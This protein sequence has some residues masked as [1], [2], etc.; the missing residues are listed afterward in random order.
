MIRNTSLLLGAF[1]VLTLACVAWAYTTTL[2]GEL[3]ALRAAGEV[4]LNEAA[5]RLRLQ[6][7]GFRAQ[8]N[9]IADTPRVERAVAVG[10]AQG[11][12]DFLIGLSLTY[13]ASRIDVIGAG[14]Q[15][16]SSSAGDVTVP[17]PSNGLMQAALNERLGFEHA[18]EE[19]RRVIRLSRGVRTAESVNI[20]AVVLTIDVAELEFQW[21]VTPEPL[22]FFDDAKLSFSSNRPALL[23]LSLADDPEEPEFELRQNGRVAGFDLWDFTAPG[24]DQA[25]EV[26]VLTQPVPHLLLTGQIILDTAPARAAARLQGFL[27]LALALVLGLVAA[28]AVQQR[29]RFALETRHS[30]TLEA[31]VEE[32]TAELKAAQGE[33]VE[34]SKLAALGRLS[35]GVSHELNQPLAA[36][37]NFSENARKFIDRDKPQ[38]V[39]ENLGLISGQVQRITRIIGNLRAF[40]RQEAAPR[41]KIDFTEVVEAA[42]D[43]V[44]DDLEAAGITSDV[45]LPN[46]P[47][48]I[49]AGRVRLEQVVLNLLTNA[50]DAMI[51]APEKRLT[52][53]LE[54]AGDD[55][56]LVVQDTGA[57]ISDPDRVFEP[58]YTTKDLG[59]SKGLGMGLALSF[60]IVTRFG[61]TLTC[62]NL[63]PGAAFK[64]A[65]PLVEET[66][67]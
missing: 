58:F 4:R 32:R 1:L 61:G 43:L 11:T 31:R 41:E 24:L 19:G 47:V 50:M 53:R 22:V 67:A 16:I 38:A 8:A 18:I 15:V 12:E 49:L 54:V 21:P 57:G 59:A 62:K 45:M 37:L 35:A 48:T 14:G 63:S 55:A 25:Q 39:S 26:L 7:D 23:L 56:V 40:A 20:G 29:R 51:D 42:F 60:G 34:A 36:I 17:V 28:V 65:L 6:I 3:G 64:I 9:F 5:S 46:G 10:Q 13:G 2:R 30:A 52:L 44:R 66:D 27:A 33:L